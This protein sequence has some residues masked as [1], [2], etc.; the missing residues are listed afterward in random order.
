MVMLKQKQLISLSILSLLALAMAQV[1]C[2]S[3]SDKKPDTNGKQGPRAENV[4]VAPSPRIDRITLMVDSASAINWNE[5]PGPDGVRI[6]IFLWRKEGTRWDAVALKRGT[7]ELT[8][9]DGK[10]ET[11]QLPDIKPSHKW[12][13]SADQIKKAVN[14]R[15]VGK[16]YGFALGFGKKLPKADI[17]T[18]SVRI[19]N[20]GGS[21]MYAE[22]VHL[23]MKP[24]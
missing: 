10:F 1:G 14:V 4:V 16:V 3:T 15:P 17:I 20:P 24:R 6:K 7:I 5:K 11:Y 18:V 8:L 2:Q 12:R 22:P 19:L 13:Y 9:Y 21:P 23:T